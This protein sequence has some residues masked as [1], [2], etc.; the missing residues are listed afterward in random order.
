MQGSY[1]ETQEIA[2][3]YKAQCTPEFYL[4]D[5]ENKLIYRGRLDDSS[6]GNDKKVNGNDLREAMDNFLSSKEVQSKQ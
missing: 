4:F 3:K 6:P 1:D 5:K 2:K